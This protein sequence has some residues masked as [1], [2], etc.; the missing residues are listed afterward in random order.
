LP[1]EDRDDWEHHW[2]SFS[3]S[4]GRNPAQAWRRRLVLTALDLQP[5]DRL[6]DV[7]SGQGDL[8]VAALAASPGVEVVGLELG[9]SG[10]AAAAV[11]APRARFH[12]LDL[13]G[14]E[15]AVESLRGWA[16]KVSC[17][18]VL[19]HVDEP[20][21]FLR[22]ALVHAARGA[23]VVVTVPAGP[24]TAFDV[25]I[26]HRRHYDRRSLQRTLEEAGLDVTKIRA[27]GFPMFNLY[28]LV[29]LARGKRLVADATSSGDQGSTRLASAVMGTF[30]RLIPLSANNGL[31]W[32]LVAEATY[33]ANE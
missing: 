26:G 6:L 3:E 21:A 10:V 25:H 32:Q 30:R 18:E 16:T 31:G 27:A 8:A 28:R 17:S 7:G 2:S 4:A 12:A 13:L 24:R 9:R 5:T 22:N 23:Q 14:P 11:K 20:V 1:S 33:R 15:P 29:V 19:E